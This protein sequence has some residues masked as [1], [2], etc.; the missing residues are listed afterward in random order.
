VARDTVLIAGH[1]GDCNLGD[2]AIA[3]VLVRAVATNPCVRRIRLLTLRNRPDMRTWARDT[4]QLLIASWSGVRSLI[5]SLLKTRVIIVGGGGILQDSTSVANIAIHTLLP[6]LLRVF[7]IRILVVGVGI[8]PLRKR[9]SRVLVQLLLRGA[10]VVAVRDPMSHQQC[11]RMGVAT[12]KLALAPDLAWAWPGHANFLVARAPKRMLVSIRPPIGPAEVRE[13]PTPE[14]LAQVALILSAINDFAAIHGFSVYVLSTHPLQDGELVRRVLQNSRK[15]NA[16]SILEPISPEELFAS[17]EPGDVLV[18]MRLHAQI[19]AALN[20]VP[21]IALAYAEKVTIAAEALSMTQYAQ[22]FPLGR[23]GLE[24]LGQ[25]LQDLIDN[26]PAISASVLK[27]SG[28]L[29]REVREMLKRMVEEN[30]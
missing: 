5:N 16:I 30:V 6:L 17:F 27:R 28:E 2:D 18:G 15:L 22:S 3:Q 14:Y 26:Y 10:K 24:K 11:I 1:Y 7:G 13:K 19:L 21:A 25:Q 4:D 9:V 20:G 12:G 23:S 8:G 29:S